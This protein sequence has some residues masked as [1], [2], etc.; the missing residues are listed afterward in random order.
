MIAV[1]ILIRAMIFISPG[2]T[3]SIIFPINANDTLVPGGSMDAEGGLYY[4][5]RALISIAGTG[6]VVVA[7]S[8]RDTGWQIMTTPLPLRGRN[9]VHGEWGGGGEWREEEARRWSAGDHG[10]E[11][12]E[13][14]AGGAR[15]ARGR[16]WLTR[17]SNFFSRIIW[18]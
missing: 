5:C 17:G 1:A 15:R 14:D 6:D 2:V 4:L 13:A 18:Y 12:V 8:R 10:G 9:I 7:G 16:W 3:V 11:E